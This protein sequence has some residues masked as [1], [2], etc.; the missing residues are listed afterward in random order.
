MFER[1]CANKVL[2]SAISVEAGDGD[3]ISSKDGKVDDVPE[4]GHIGI[5][6]F[7]SKN[8]VGSVAREV[9]LHQCTHHGQQAG[10][11]GNH[12]LAGKL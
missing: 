2:L 5:R 8:A 12:G 3:P 10:G 4:N 6:T 1:W 7:P 9:H 11:N